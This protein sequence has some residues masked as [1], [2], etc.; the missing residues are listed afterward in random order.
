[1][2][3]ICFGITKNPS[4]DD[5]IMVFRYAK[6]GDL[7]H[8]LKEKGK[9]LSWEIRIHY[10]LEIMIRIVRIHND[11]FIHRDIHGGNILL[12]IDEDF[13]DDRNTDQLDVLI[14]DFGLSRPAN[15]PL[16]NSRGTY[17]IIPYIA[18]EVLRGEP[19]T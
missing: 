17:G 14:A 9:D 10:F 3:P 8:F 11:G 2:T 16:S 7:C 15:E 4:E 6:G 12:D 5:Y 1:M 18:P 19:R 13:E